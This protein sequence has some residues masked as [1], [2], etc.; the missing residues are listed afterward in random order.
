[1]ASWTRSSRASSSTVGST[2]GSTLVVVVVNVAS[3]LVS[4][5]PL[6]RESVPEDSLNKTQN[7]H[8]DFKQR[9]RCFIKKESDTL[10][11]EGAEA[12][13]HDGVVRGV[14]FSG[15]LVVVGVVDVGDLVLVVYLRNSS[16]HMSVIVKICFESR[17][18][19][20]ERVSR[21]ATRGGVA[22]SKHRRRRR[23]RL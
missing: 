8:S 22:T 6:V 9:L 18:R 15:V 21:V 2:L 3:S 4:H 5:Q 14:L 19:R 20:G 17:E 12:V 16:P 10:R 7:K 13:P 23:R 1:M 11:L